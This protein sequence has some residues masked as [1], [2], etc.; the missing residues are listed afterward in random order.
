MKLLSLLLA[1][2]A[3][4]PVSVSADPLVTAEFAPE[5]L[6]TSFGGFG[7]EGFTAFRGQAFE[8]LVDGPILSIQRLDEHDEPYV[9]ELYDADAEGR[10]IGEAIVSGTFPA[11]MVPMSPASDKT[12]FEF[13][14][15]GSLVAGRA[16]VIT[17]GL[18][19]PI[20]GLN[21][22]ILGGLGS[23]AATYA[24]PSLYSG[25]ATWTPSDIT[26]WSFRVT[27]DGST[28]VE[29]ASWGQVKHAF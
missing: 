12:V 14:A 27:V 3:A 8:A 28:P 25:G 11:S 16:Y 10:P 7:S 13:G 19:T 29:T 5:T 24:W 15:A 23:T 21:N 1:L 26:D 18:E 9:G 4:V 2:A 22:S 20:S 17:I 6:G